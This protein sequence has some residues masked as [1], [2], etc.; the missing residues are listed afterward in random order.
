MTVGYRNPNG[1]KSKV[2]PVKQL[3]A[4][5]QVVQEK[6]TSLLAAIRGGEQAARLLKQIQEE[7]KHEVFSDEA[8]FVY[9]MRTCRV[10]YAD[11]G[12]V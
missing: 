8:A 7:C 3:S 11:L 4:G 6:V 9:N 12:P 10:C 1:D 2:E 5:Q